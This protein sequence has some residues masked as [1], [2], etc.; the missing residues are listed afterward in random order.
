MIT[1]KSPRQKKIELMFI[2]TLNK[3]APG[4]EEE[5]FELWK[6]GKV[7]VLKLI[8]FRN[9]YDSKGY[10]SGYEDGYNKGYSSEYWE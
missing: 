10:N 4:S 2:K 7:D 3:T 1:R 5:F 8:K 6:T 9:F